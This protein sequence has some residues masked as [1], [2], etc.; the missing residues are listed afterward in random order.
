MNTSPRIQMGPMGGGT[1]SPRQTNL[2]AHLRNLHNVM[3]R[4]E[5][6]VNS[7]NLEINL[8]EV[9]KSG[10]INDVFPAYNWCSTKSFV[11]GSHFFNRSSNQ[12]SSS[13]GNCLTSTLT[14]AF[15]SKFYT[16]HGELPVSLS[17]NRNICEFPRVV[18]TI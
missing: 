14:K 8:G 4:L 9:W 2:L 18:I 11:D 16:V 10:A 17:R 13:V 7:S 1:S 15:I 3:L 6:E 12:R 5:R